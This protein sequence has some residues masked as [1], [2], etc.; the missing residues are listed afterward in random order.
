MQYMVW[1]ARCDMQCVCVLRKENDEQDI[2]LA[3]QVCRWKDEMIS[4]EIDIK[5]TGNGC[6]VCK[7]QARQVW[8]KAAINSTMLLSMQQETMLQHPNMKTKHMEIIYRRCFTKEEHWGTANSHH[9]RFKQAWRKC[10]KL[11][12]WTWHKQQHEAMFRASYQHA[13]GTYNSKLRHGMNLLK[14]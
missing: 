14:A 8:H 2:N 3:N 10:K 1:Y 12:D 5:I 7:W 9:N 6:T 13:T 4:V 11:S